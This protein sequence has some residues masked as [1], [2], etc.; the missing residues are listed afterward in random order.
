[1]T[2]NCFI[3]PDDVLERFAAD[4]ELSDEVRQNFH[5]SA[6]LSRG[7][8]AVR[9]RNNALTTTAISLPFP[10]P[11]FPFPLPHRLPIGQVFDCHH[12]TTLPGAAVANPGT[13]ADATVKRG[14]VEEE[15]VARFYW[16]IFK[17]DSIDGHHMTLISSVHYGVKYNNAFWNG[18]QM[19]YGD[20]DGQVFL[21]FTLG[22]D[23]IGHELTHGVTQHSLGLVYSGEAGGLNESMSDVFGSMFRQWEKSQTTATADW[24]IGH[25]IMGPVSTGKG[26]TCLRNMAVPKDVHALAAQP[27]HYYPGIG[28]LDPHYSSGVPNLAF[29]NAAKAIGGHS[30]EKAGQV[31]Y[32]ALTGF[33]PSPNMT[34]SQFASRTRALSTSMFPAEPAVHTAVNTAWTAVGL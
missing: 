3:I 5:H 12:G 27:D 28:N 15:S 26:Y 11:P 31:W 8:R 21:D 24:L 9:D 4:P 18:A 22:D 23:V 30:W 2:C 20:G 13:S 29:T 1:M 17:L 33:G 6:A 14:Y 34:M 16:N 19:T 7:I 32:K 25:D 10:R